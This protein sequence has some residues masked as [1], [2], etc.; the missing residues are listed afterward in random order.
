MRNLF[1]F[2]IF[3]LSVLILPAEIRSQDWEFTREKDGIKVFTR[4][5]SGNY[6]SYRGET[7]FRAEVSAI[8]EI[9]EDMEK[10]TEWDEDIREMKVLSHKKGRS[11]TYYTVYDVPWPFSDR[12]LCVKDTI[13]TDPSTGIVTVTGISAPDEVPMNKDYVRITEF[14]EKWIIEP[15]GNGFI[16][17]ILEGF[18][19]PAGDIPAWAANLAVTDTPLNMIRAIK[20]RI[21]KDNKV[22]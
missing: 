4:E 16:R 11:L 12:D 15:I 13:I 14:H 9:I 10:L 5:E 3:I 7:E 6:K 2:H 20:E 21:G 18:A 17:L 1:L 8:L 19:H 22:E